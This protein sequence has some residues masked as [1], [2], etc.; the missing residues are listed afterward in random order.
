[1][2]NSKQ[3]KELLEQQYGEKTVKEIFS[4]TKILKGKTYNE[5]QDLIDI[6]KFQLGSESFIR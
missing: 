1:M 2:E 6:V 5:A 3:K 4:I